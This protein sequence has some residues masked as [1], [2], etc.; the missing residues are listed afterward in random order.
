MSFF[1]VS[2]LIFLSVIGTPK[3]IYGGGFLK[4]WNT[5]MFFVFFSIAMGFLFII[6][7][8][9]VEGHLGKKKRIYSYAKIQFIEFQDNWRSNKYLRELPQ[10]SLSKAAYALFC[11]GMYSAFVVG[12]HG[13]DFDSLPNLM[14]FIGF[15]FVFFKS[16]LSKV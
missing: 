13:G 7:F 1:V 10:I 8:A 5:S 2:T 6:P 9:V 3:T 12:D 14:L 4:F 16:I 15:G 11:F